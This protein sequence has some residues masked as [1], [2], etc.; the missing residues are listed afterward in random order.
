MLGTDEEISVQALIR[1]CNNMMQPRTAA[2]AELLRAAR[3]AM[4]LLPA[5]TTE[6]PTTRGASGLGFFDEYEG[7]RLP[8]ITGTSRGRRLGVSSFDC[9]A[10]GLQRP[11]LLT[12]LPEPGRTSAR[13]RGRHYAAAPAP[14]LGPRGGHG[15]NLLLLPEQAKA[16]EGELSLAAAPPG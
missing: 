1:M 2:T 5:A 14:H 13:R 11:E 4:A 12:L 16:I 15:T 10:S 9:G 3:M 7:V 6:R 8:L